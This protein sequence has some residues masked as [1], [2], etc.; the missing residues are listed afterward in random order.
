[1]TGAIIALAIKN[2]VAAV[3]L[4]FVSHFL[5]DTIPHFGVPPGEF[6]MQKY[7]KYLIADFIVL[8]LSVLIIALLFTQHFWLILV[9]MATATIPDLVW[10]FYRKDLEKN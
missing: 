8:S 3:S 4:A 2:P 1:M 10:W 5:L 6:V 7:K 9:C